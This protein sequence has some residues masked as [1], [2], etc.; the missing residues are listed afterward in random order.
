MLITTGQELAASSHA[1]DGSPRFEVIVEGERRGLAPMI[2][3]RSGNPLI[4]I[5][6]VSLGATVAMIGPGVWSI[7]AR[8]YGRKHIEPSRQ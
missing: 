7:D 8:L 5:M 3:A 6:L 4:A 1:E 2:K